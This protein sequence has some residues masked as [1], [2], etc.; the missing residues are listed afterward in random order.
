VYVRATAPV[1][2]TSSRARI[3]NT[4]VFIFVFDFNDE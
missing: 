2:A 4:F 1:A 3:D